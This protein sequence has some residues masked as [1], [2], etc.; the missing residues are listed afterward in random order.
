MNRKLVFIGLKIAEIVAVVFIPYYLGLFARTKWPVFWADGPPC[1]IAGIIIMIGLLMLFAMGY[2]CFQ[3][4]KEL[5][6]ANWKWA[7]KIL[8]K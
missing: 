7:G 1:W 6:K 2:V 4:S 8:K 5:I 3:G